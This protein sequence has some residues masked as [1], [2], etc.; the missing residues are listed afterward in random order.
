MSFTVDPK[1][2]ERPKGTALITQNRSGRI[3]FWISTKAIKPNNDTS[4]WK[5]AD[6]KYLGG[7][8]HCG[9]HTNTAWK[10]ACYAVGVD[11]S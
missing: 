11:G 4:C 1:L 3:E 10:G 9:D 6:H 2:V 7:V 5:G 8:S